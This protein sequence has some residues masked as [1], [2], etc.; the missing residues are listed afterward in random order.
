M[1]IRIL[2]QHELEIIK[3]LAYRIWPLTYGNIISQEQMAYMLEWMYSLE[4]LESNFFNNHTYF[5]IALNGTDVGFLDIETNHP[6]EGNMKIHKIY[7][8]P[9]FHGKSVGFEL[10]NK[11]KDFANENEM[12]SMSL[13][14]NRNNSA[15]D[16]YKRFGFEIIDEQDF[17]I[18]NG[19][20]MNDFVMSYKIKV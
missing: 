6:E 12:K 10:M 3:D 2:K 15:V 13:Q 20:Y 7:V 8:L 16:F 14:V 4:N 1:E 17:E 19:F 11:A 9:E 5:C 18:G